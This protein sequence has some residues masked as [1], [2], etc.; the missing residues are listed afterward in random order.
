[1]PQT[2][3]LPMLFK[4]SMF[5]MA[6]LFIFFYKLKQIQGHLYVIFLPDCIL[7]YFPQKREQAESWAQL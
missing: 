7:T 4:V 1:M 6:Y 3:L 2:V 5:V